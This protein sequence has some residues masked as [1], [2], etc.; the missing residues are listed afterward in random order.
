M[1]IEVY[2]TANNTF[3]E[4]DPVE[5]LHSLMA[6]RSIK[7]IELASHLETSRGN[8]SDILNYKKSL[9][10]EMIR[11]LALLF[12]VTQEAFNRPY[13]LIKTISGPKGMADVKSVR[14]SSR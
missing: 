3:N 7:S 9:S 8:I 2:D 12:N 11:K 6:E 13:T 4:L 10:K 5:L 1:L 14:A